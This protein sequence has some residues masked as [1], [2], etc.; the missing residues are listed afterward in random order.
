MKT[1]TY[2]KQD[3][4]G[5]LSLNRPEALNAVNREMLEEMTEFLGNVTNIN[6][7]ILTGAGGKAFA[8]GAD[9]R[10]MSGLGPEKIAEFSR[11]GQD[12]IKTLEEVSFITIAAVRGFALGGGLEIAMGCDLIYA[13]E[14]AKFGLPEIKLGLIPGWGGTYRLARAIGKRRAKEVMLT[15]RMFSADEAYDLGLVNRVFPEDN[16]MDECLKLS[17][18]M[19]K[20]SPFALRQIKQALN[21]DDFDEERFVECFATEEAQRDIEQFLQKQKI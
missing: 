8:A 15:G 7:L 4:I 21:Q 6:I 9:V 13:S 1:L 12:V 10:E 16:L 11:L 5:I 2:S 18:G 17:K 14:K 3:T 19:L 20:Y